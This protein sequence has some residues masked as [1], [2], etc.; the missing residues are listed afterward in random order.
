MAKYNRERQLIGNVFNIQRYTIHDGPGIRTEVF[1]K[2]CPLNCKWCSNPESINPFPEIGVYPTS[3]VGVEKCG[4]CL[5]V[6]PVEGRGAL[7]VQD[8]KIAS[9]DRG[10][11]TNCMA[12]G[13][14]CPND[15]LKIFGAWM[16]V[17][18]V[19]RPIL[20]DRAFYQRT[21]GGV[22]VSGGD[23]LL[24]W[25]FTL[26]LLRRCKFLGI[27]TCVETE[28]Q[29]MWKIV[30]EICPHADLWIAD[31]K[32]MDNEAH[33]HYTGAGNERIL[34]NLKKLVESGARVVLR[35]PV[36]KG[37]NDT[38]ENIA[39]MGAYIRDHLGNR[40]LQHQLIPYRLLGEDKYAA[41]GRPFSR[42]TE[43]APQREEYEPRIRRIAERLQKEYGVP[44]VAGS[45]TKINL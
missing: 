22:T 12:C 11:C 19:M 17:D 40:V 42:M 3:C 28:L 30:E 25:E 13:K 15:T 24:Q 32:L 43:A 29:T 14:A 10:L 35:T 41:L 23:A 45:T 33:R 36:I 6:C 27:Q 44:A 16:T 1:L 20:S 8:G 18:E 9:I 34:E 26:E 38:D 37:I 7:I 39:A 4:H 31:I 21:G 2:G 5:K